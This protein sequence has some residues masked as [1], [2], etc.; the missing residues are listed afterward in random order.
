MGHKHLFFNDDFIDLMDVKYYYDTHSNLTYL[1]Y[2]LAKYVHHAQTFLKNKGY[3]YVFLFAADHEKDMLT[4]T[5][6]F[7]MLGFNQNPI[8]DSYP[9]FYHTIKDIDAN[10]VCP[11]SFTTYTK[12]ANCKFGLFNHPLEDGH[13]LYSNRLMEFIESKYGHKE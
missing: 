4:S 5:K 1:M 12:D 11:L 3:K 8:L 10:L 2:N 9:N 13:I 6:F 7:E